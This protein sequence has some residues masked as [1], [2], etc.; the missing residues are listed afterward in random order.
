MDSTNPIQI[1]PDEFP[2]AL[3]SKSAYT[4]WISLLAK[5]A[6]RAAQGQAA[7]AEYTGD[8]A[9]TPNS[10][11]ESEVELEVDDKIDVL[12][13]SRTPFDVLRFS[14]QHPSEP[15]I[16]T[17]SPAITT[18]EAALQLAHDA[19]V[20]DVLKEVQDETKTE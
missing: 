16:D 14:D 13:K 4:E 19:L 15:I 3:S 1:M 11:Y 6:I 2:E 18:R 20:Q 10:R 12:T 17:I 5:N 8:L 7:D 9:D